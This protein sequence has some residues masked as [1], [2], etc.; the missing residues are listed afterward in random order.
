M[1]PQKR[2]SLTCAVCGIP[3]DVKRSHA[4]KRKTCSRKCHGIHMARLF[5][6]VDK[7]GKIDGSCVICGK[8]VRKRRTH[9]EKY[10]TVCSKECKSKLQTL[11]MSG[12]N[13]PLYKGL[14][15]VQCE[16][17]GAAL[18]RYPCHANTFERFF[19]NLQCMGQWRKITGVTRAERNGAWKGGLVAV[20]CAVCGKELQREPNQVERNDNHFCDHVCYGAWLSAH[21]A[22]ENSP[23]WK[24]GW[25]SYYGPNWLGQRK[26]ARQRDKNTCQHC[27]I[28]ERKLG[29]RLDVHHIRPFREFGYV[30]GEN[31]NYRQANRLS[32]LISLCPSCHQQ[33]EHGKV[34]IQPMLVHDFT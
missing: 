27:G 24:G 19:C 7:G 4:E 1:P 34:P 23:S 28:T 14:I 33:V 22:G 21:N 20:H 26:K 18:K 15:D 13:N 2:V 17:C 29:K 30:V 10:R 12:E 31:E 25:K 32:N 9:V 5:G 11:T 3:F 8:V 6:G 16:N